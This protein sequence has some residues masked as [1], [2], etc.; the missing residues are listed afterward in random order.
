MEDFIYSSDAYH[1]KIL[2][3]EI[4]RIPYDDAPLIYYRVYAQID[5]EKEY[6]ITP[7]GVVH[8]KY[9]GRIVTP[10]VDD[11]GYYY[12][13]IHNKRY[14]IK[15]LIEKIFYPVP[16]NPPDTYQAV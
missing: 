7:S 14:R 13:E 4:L 1:H 15:D 16:D 2:G 9:E 5:E 8:R 6:Y 12:V 11:E 3:R 10:S